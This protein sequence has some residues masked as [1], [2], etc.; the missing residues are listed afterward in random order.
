MATV[1]L[2]KLFYSMGL[3]SFKGVFGSTHGRS[4]T[5]YLKGGRQ[6]LTS[7]IGRLLWGQGCFNEHILGSVSLACSNYELPSILQQIGGSLYEELVELQ[8]LGRFGRAEDVA[9]RRTVSA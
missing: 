7:G 9:A 1:I 5:P 8:P 6:E 3:N 2:D 4:Y